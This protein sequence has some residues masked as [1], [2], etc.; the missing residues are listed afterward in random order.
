M[1]CQISFPAC[2]LLLWTL[3]A[4]VSCIDA[5]GEISVKAVSDGIELNCNDQQ[6]STKSNNF[7]DVIRLRYQDDDTGEYSCSDNRTKIFVKFRTC[8]NCVHL[9]RDS[10][11]GII[12]GN[13][14]A[15]I[16]IGVAV[17]LIASQ[18]KTGPTASHNKSSDRQ[19]LVPNEVSS[20]SVDEHYQPLKPKHGQ[21][22]TYDVLKNR[23]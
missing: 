18:T 12:V 21:R 11:V 15:T 23:R 13:V 16:V 3:T 20:R 19:H 22:E 17:Y 6:I 5:P 4:S 8:D 2:L 14:V 10:I 9:D 1:K 7:A